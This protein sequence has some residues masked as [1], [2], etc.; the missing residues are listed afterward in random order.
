M[1]KPPERTIPQTVPEGYSGCIPHLGGPVSEA[2][3][4]KID[5]Y[6]FRVGIVVETMAGNSHDN[7]RSP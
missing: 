3:A 5:D 6:Y 7:L 2:D 4:L 1:M